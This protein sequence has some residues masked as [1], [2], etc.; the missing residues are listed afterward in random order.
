MNDRALLRR[1]VQVHCKQR[2]T[3]KDEVYTEGLDASSAQVEAS[4]WTTT[5]KT[6]S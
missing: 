2:K 1:D 3:E 6:M 4:C 5:P